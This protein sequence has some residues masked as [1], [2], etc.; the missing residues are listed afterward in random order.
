MDLKKLEGEIKQYKSLVQI[1]D[2]LLRLEDNKDFQTI[3]SNGYLGDHLRVLV[4]KRNADLTPDNAVSRQID[5]VSNLM[6]YLSNIKTIG[7]T[8]RASLAESEQTLEEHFEE[9]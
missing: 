1:A 2:A 4:S 7:A 5:S 9:E 6:A 3:I 8:A